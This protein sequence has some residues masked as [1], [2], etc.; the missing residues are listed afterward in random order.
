M[1]TKAMSGYEIIENELRL[2]KLKYSGDIIV[3]IRINGSL[4]S[5][6]LNF[7]TDDYNIWVWENDWWEG[8]ENVEFVGAQLLNDVIIKGNRLEYRE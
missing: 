6:L 1:R 3:T 4:I 8:E 5:E 7:D 2:D